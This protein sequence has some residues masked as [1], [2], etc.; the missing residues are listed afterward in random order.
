VSTLRPGKV[1]QAIADLRDAAIKEMDAIPAGVEK[2]EAITFDSGHTAP[3]AVS[4]FDSSNW[5]ARYP[6]QNSPHIGNGAGG[7]R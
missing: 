2:P 4:D 5:V 1:S 3:A 6:G 7:V